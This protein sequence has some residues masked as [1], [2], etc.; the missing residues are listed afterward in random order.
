MNIEKKVKAWVENECKKPSSKYGY[1][2]FIYH[3]S[4]MVSYAIKL[5]EEMGADKEIVEVAGWLHDIGSIIEGR[6]NH[7]ISGARI[8]EEKLK[9][10]NYPQDKIEA[11]KKC[12]LNHR[13]SLNNH[14]ESIE[15]IVVAE[16]DVLSNFDNISGLFKAAFEYEGL[17]Q[18]DARKS[19][20]QKLKNKYKQLHLEKSKKLIEPKYRAAILL[21]SDKK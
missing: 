1:E 15:E 18:K 2:P 11:V 13:G 14:R 17:S 12:I 4:P 20:L 6:E 9:N 19:V 21:L 16:A 10:F 5:A 3:F 8:A 7:H